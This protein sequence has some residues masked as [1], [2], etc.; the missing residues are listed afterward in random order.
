MVAI[1]LSSRGPGIAGNFME[2]A[3]MVP[4]PIGGS[5]YIYFPAVAYSGFSQSIFLH[6]FVCIRSL[7]VSGLPGNHHSV[8]Q[9]DRA[10]GPTIERAAGMAGAWNHPGAGRDTL[11]AHL[12]AKP[13]VYRQR[14]TLSQNYS[15]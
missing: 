3:A 8:R 10:T 6:L 4:R 2:S 7:A 1:H 12:A 5:A 11:R 9:W 15:P 14:N 13:D